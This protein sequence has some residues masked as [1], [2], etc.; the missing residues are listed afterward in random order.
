[1]LERQTAADLPLQSTLRTSSS[2]P[3]LRIRLSIT[4]QA[5]SRLIHKRERKAL[6]STAALANRKLS[7]HAL[8]KSTT[9]TRRLAIGASRVGG[10]RGKGLVKLL[11]V[12]SVLEFEGCGGAVGGGGGDGGRGVG[13]GGGDGD[14]LDLG[15]CYGD[16][17]RV[18]VFAGAGGGSG[19]DG[20]CGGGGR[21]GA[22]V[23][24]VGVVTSGRAGTGALDE[25][26]ELCAV[27]DWSARVRRTRSSR[28][29]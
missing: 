23:P 27:C 4:S 21:G 18:F 29:E 25:G 11:S 12:E 17:V 6:R 28:I 1:M 16:L 5:R 22:I 9:H 7:A 2:N 10:E 8:R 19:G 15:D 20:G 13:A 24:A 26:V 14:G 3:R